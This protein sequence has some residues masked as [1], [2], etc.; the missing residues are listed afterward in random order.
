MATMFRLGF[1]ASLALWL[2][3]QSTLVH[4]ESVT[5]DLATFAN[6]HLTSGD[7]PITATFDMGTQFS[8]IDSIVLKVTGHAQSGIGN[9]I[10]YPS[11]P[12][13][14]VDLN[15]PNPQPPPTITVIPFV[16]QLFA[17]IPNGTDY[18]PATTE[19]YPNS[20]N[21]TLFTSA[22][23]VAEAFPFIA[24]DVFDGLYDGTG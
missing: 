9:L 23:T 11:P 19:Q 8:S 24:E 2:L 17:S 18:F 5:I 1:I 10:S 3:N 13:I 7:A 20:V 16:P 15:N 4:A 22:I 14:I 12:Y 21:P 6:T